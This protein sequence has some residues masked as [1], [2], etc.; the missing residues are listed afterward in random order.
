MAIQIRLSAPGPE[1][2]AAVEAVHRAFTVVSVSGRRDNR[3]GDPGERLHIVATGPAAGGPESSPL[4][5]AEDAKRRRDLGAE[6]GALQAGERELKTQPWYP[7]QPGDVVLCTLPP[8]VAG[9]EPYGETYLA[10]ADDDPRL[11]DIDGGPMLRMVS[12]TDLALALADAASA[13]D[14]DQG[15]DGDGEPADQAWTQPPCSF[16]DLWFEAGPAALTVIRAGR[17]V[18]G[19]PTR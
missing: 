11:T 13:G 9:E 12:G 17:I 10:A 8:L 6:I 3:K 16:Y 7:L 1:L 4:A 14:E 18:H 2:D 5:Q 19:H 15:D